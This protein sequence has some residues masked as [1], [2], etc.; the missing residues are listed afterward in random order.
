MSV[1]SLA[2]SN[3]TFSG[4]SGARARHC[5]FSGSSDVALTGLTPYSDVNAV[6]RART[7]AS[8]VR[9]ASA[10]TESSVN[11]NYCHIVGTGTG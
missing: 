2:A 4:K 9:V 11:Y 5:S 3:E 6:T 8:F 1:D 10:V 7:G